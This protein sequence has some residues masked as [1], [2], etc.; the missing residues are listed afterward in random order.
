MTSHLPVL[1]NEVVDA[2]IPDGRVPQRVIDGTVGAGG[3]SRALLDAG[4]E[5]LLGFDLDPDALALAGQALAPYL[6]NGRAALVH[7]SYARMREF[8]NSHGWSAG[9]CRSHCARPVAVAPIA[10]SYPN[11]N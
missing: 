2:L 7:A 8:A 1:L 9:Q 5:S 3:H 10:A 11:M 4:A 6:E